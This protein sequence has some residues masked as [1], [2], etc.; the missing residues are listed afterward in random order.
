MSAGHHEDERGDDEADERE[1][2]GTHFW[3]REK[4]GGRREVSRRPPLKLGDLRTLVV[5][6]TASGLAIPRLTM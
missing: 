2:H 1:S 6:L 3:G 5:G 4:A